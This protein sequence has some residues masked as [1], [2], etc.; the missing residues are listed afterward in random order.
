M[1]VRIMISSGKA[2]V[3]ASFTNANQDPIN[4]FTGKPPQPPKGLDPS[5]RKTFV[6]QYSH[7]ELK[8]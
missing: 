2:P 1:K 4:P 7:L 6:R 8:P 5:A 3:R